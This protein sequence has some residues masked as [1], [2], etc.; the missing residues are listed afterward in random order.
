MPMHTESNS[1][2]P[3]IVETNLNSPSNSSQTRPQDR[4][5]IE[6]KVQRVII[7]DSLV[8]FFRWDFTSTEEVKA[9]LQGLARNYASLRDKQRLLSIEKITLTEHFAM[10]EAKI[11]LYTREGQSLNGDFEQKAQLQSTISMKI[12]K[13]ENVKGSLVRNIDLVAQELPALLAKAD[14]ARAAVVQTKAALLEKQ[15]QLV[16]QNQA[17]PTLKEHQAMEENYKRVEADLKIFADQ[18]GAL[19]S[20]MA[21]A[22]RMADLFR[23]ELDALT[24]VRTSVRDNAPLHMWSPRDEKTFQMFKL[25]VDS[26]NAQRQ[27]QE[28]KLQ[29]LLEQEQQSMKQ[30]ERKQKFQERVDK[31]KQL[32]AT[33]GQALKELSAVKLGSVCVQ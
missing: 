18:K 3:I 5:L 14:L 32:L 30:R 4:I 10:E 22:D 24:C 7:P 13:L 25:K 28:S 19:Q 21:E 1:L 26:A 23:K 8:P 11:K 2:A 9:S 17:Q 16:L 6:L 20:S 15:T 33:L 12:N 31:N 29:M 27:A